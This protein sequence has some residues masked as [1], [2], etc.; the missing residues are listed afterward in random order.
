MCGDIEV[1]DPMTARKTCARFQGLHHHPHQLRNQE[2]LERSLRPKVC[3]VVFTSFGHQTAVGADQ[4]CR[5]QVVKYTQGASPSA[6]SPIM[7]PMMVLAFNLPHHPSP[8]HLTEQG[9]GSADRNTLVLSVVGQ[10]RLA[11]FATDAALLVP[12]EWHLR[13]EH[14]VLV[15]PDGAGLQRVGDTDGRVQVSGVDGRGQAVVGVVGLLDDLLLGREL[16]N[17]AD[18]AEDL[19]LDNLHVG[20]DV[21]EDGG[22]DEVALVAEA[23]T[24]NLAVGALLLALLDVAH[25]AV[26]LQLADLGALEG[27]LVEGVAD[28]VGGGA[29]LEGLEELVVNALLDVDARAGAAGL[30]VVEVDAEVGPRDG[31]L[32]VGVVEDNVGGLATKLQGNLLQVG[33]GGSLHDHAADDGRTSEGDLVDVHVGGQGSAGSAAETR[34]DVQNSRRETGLLDEVGEHESGQRGL[35]GRLHDDGVTRGQGGGNLPRQHEQGEVPGDN[36]G[37]DTDL[38]T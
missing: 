24:A 7:S 2:Q 9:T 17:G 15:D 21:G 16:G 33:G 11:Q 5:Y 23:L 20:S 22:L 8:Q 26:E 35:L 32:N 19:L 30:A 4:L 29:L 18:G 12:A 6:L 27:V 31:L 1:R 3:V 37:A 13:V 25:D 36:L 28:S 34:D 14:V 38:E 10:R